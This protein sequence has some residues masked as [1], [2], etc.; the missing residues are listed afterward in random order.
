MR[1][2]KLAFAWSKNGKNRHRGN[3]IHPRRSILGATLLWF[4]MCIGCSS[5]PPAEATTAAL[6]G[7]VV[8]GPASLAE[9]PDGFAIHGVG[10]DTDLLFALQPSPS[11]LTPPGVH[12]AHRLSGDNL[13]D[14]TPPPGGFLVPLTVKI[15]SFSR[16]GLAG[17]Q[18]RFLI[19]DARMPPAFIG[20]PFA[21][22][23]RLYRYSYRYTRRDGLRTTLLETHTLPLASGLPDP[24]APTLPDGILYPGS[25]ALLPGGRVAIT[26][27]IAGSIWVSDVSLNNWSLA[28]IDPR[29]A[30]A[31]RGPVEGVGRNEDGVIAPYTLLTPAPPGF[32]PGLGLFPGIHSI[33]YAAVTEEVCFPV[34]FPGGI[35]CIDES[36][37]SDAATPPFLKSAAVRVVVPPT[38]GLGDLT[39]GLDYDRFHPTSPWLYWQR[40]PADVAGGGY[41]TL[42]RVHL[43]TGAIEV[44]ASDNELYSW[45]N[46]ISV[47]PPLLS[48]GRWTWILSSV[49]QE[50]NNPDVNVLLGG[51]SSYFAPSPMP[52]VAIRDF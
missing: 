23:A 11:P 3:V 10:G 28:I 1:H 37:L 50:Y 41:N 32:P 29:F 46:E 8:A 39:D 48:D 34:T 7:S 22:N 42:R 13:G 17:T 16:A 47:L 19:M 45:A 12:V 49:G 52:A 15:E 33:A 21:T 9:F 38:P 2:T 14:V 26:D 44:V 20:S 51:V 5:D 6:C 24:S 18:G 25:I 35:Y 40:A 31:P 36:V 30:G 27:N 43:L 4:I